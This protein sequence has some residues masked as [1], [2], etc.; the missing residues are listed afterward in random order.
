MLLRSTLRVVCAI[1][2]SS[3]GRAS[4]A[5]IIAV[6]RGATAPAV[7]SANRSTRTAQTSHFVTISSA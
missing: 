6:N 7:A 4:G 3:G 1:E 2:D 5:A